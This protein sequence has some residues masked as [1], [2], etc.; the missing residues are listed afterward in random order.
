MNGSR[1]FLTGCDCLDQTGHDDFVVR[2]GRCLGLFV[3]LSGSEVICPLVCPAS[4]TYAQYPMPEKKALAEQL[5]AVEAIIPIYSVFVG[6]RYL[7]H[8]V[9]SWWT[10]HSLCCHTYLILSSYYL[11]DTVA[12]SYKSTFFVVK[13][14]ATVSGRR[15]RSRRYAKPA[16]PRR[17]INPTKEKSRRNVPLQEA[18]ISAEAQEWKITT[19]SIS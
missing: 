14:P 19:T 11:K 5:H 1:H 13:K 8:G 12:L 4:N 3:L 9:C 15:E 18:Q 7:Q 10:S 2:E 17:T 16:E 6:H